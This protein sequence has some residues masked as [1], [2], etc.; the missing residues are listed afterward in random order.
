MR[1]ISWTLQSGSD[2]IQLCFQ[3]MSNQAD[4]RKHTMDCEDF[5]QKLVYK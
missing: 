2:Q 3:P 4:S 1:L 5:E